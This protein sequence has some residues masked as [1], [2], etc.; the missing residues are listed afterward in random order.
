MPDHGRYEQKK[1]KI[2]III[3][4]SLVCLTGC[5]TAISHGF[6]ANRI[7]SGTR[8]TF[9]MYQNDD[10]TKLETDVMV[11]MTVFNIIDLPLCLCADTIILPVTLP[12]STFGE[13][14]EFQQ[15]IN[16]K[17]DCVCGQ[18]PIKETK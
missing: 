17:P 2:N 1:M 11:F 18:Y 16:P 12:A 13:Y 14:G 4:L 5:K 9:E 7:Y 3:I 15:M 8:F 6:G 10:E